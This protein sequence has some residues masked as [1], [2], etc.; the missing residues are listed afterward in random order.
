MDDLTLNKTLAM[1]IGWPRIALYE[2][3]K[4]LYIAVGKGMRKFDYKDWAVIG[5]IAAEYNCFPK[6]ASQ[7]WQ[8]EYII[9][10]TDKT[11]SIRFQELAF[12]E[13]PQK[14]I[15]KAVLRITL[16]PDN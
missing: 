3:G 16:Y 11:G 6:N 9:K 5:P 12:G 13:T 10:M 15:A 4:S 8:V 7:Q 1:A 2:F 14:A